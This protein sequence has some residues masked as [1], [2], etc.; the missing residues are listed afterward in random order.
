[1]HGW[2]PDK[3][4]NEGTAAHTGSR[5]A[6]LHPAQHE[7]AKVCCCCCRGHPKL[8]PDPAL[9]QHREVR[10]GRGHLLLWLVG[11]AQQPRGGACREGKERGQS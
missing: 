11:V 1:M 4:S 10:V 6:R 8:A 7:V 2:E 9:L 5:V 3:G